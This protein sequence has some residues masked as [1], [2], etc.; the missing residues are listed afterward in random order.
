MKIDEIGAGHRLYWNDPDD[1]KC[2]GW[3]T[4]ISVIG[5]VVLCEEDSGGTV[6][7]PPE[8]LTERPE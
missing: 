2:S 3:V 7:C 1:D 5:D 6:E 4:V 8:E